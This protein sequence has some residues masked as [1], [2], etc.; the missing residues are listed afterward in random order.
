MSLHRFAATL[1]LALCIALPG[2]GHAAEAPGGTLAATPPLGWNSW[3]SYGLSVTA[4]EWKSNVDWFHQHLQPAGWQYVVVDEGWY[5]A[6]PENAA[7][8]G[9][10]GYTVDEYGRYTPDIGRFPDG[11]TG[12]ASYAHS[13]GL[14]FGIHIIRG[15]PKEAVQRNLAIAESTFHAADAADTT[16]TCR[17]N[18]DNYGIKDNAA[19][20]AYYDSLLKLYAGWGVD[21]LKVDCISKPY[22][23]HE[24]H[25]ISGSITKAARPIVLSL[26]PG[27]TPL[28]A[29]ADVDKY[30]QMWRISDDVWDIW[31]DPA[32]PEGGFPQ[33]VRRQFTTLANWMQYQLPG[34]WPDAD[35]LPIGY[36]GP[37]P[38]WG[39]P[40]SSRLNHDETRTML[41]LWAIARSPMVLGSNLLQL[42][43]STETLLTNRAMIAV[44]QQSSNNKELLVNGGLV[45]W[46][47]DAPK[48]AAGKR[49]YYYAVFNLG[50]TPMPFLYSWKQL[51]LAGKEHHV[52]DLWETQEKG[53]AEKLQGT[54]PPH[55]SA[56][57]RVDANPS[58][59]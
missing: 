50:D 37:R 48:S 20:Q 5:L 46:R 16:D 15:I 51:S 24:V 18:P 2:L 56:L 38:G 12:L 1:L 11:L 59:Q 6:H 26:S 3:D 14:R 31:N 47:A 17:W 30:A 40:R 41:T 19:G 34:H 53:R 33:S 35:M 21:F 28:T 44:D 42:D 49:G 10:Q 45:V 36:L 54:L 57:F 52:F 4:Q 55:G 8:K 27:P 39:Q 25:M 43:S 58:R 13:L 7:G 29:A 22:D 9:D 32:I 23:E